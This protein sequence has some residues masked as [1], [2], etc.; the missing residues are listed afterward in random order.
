MPAARA[1]CAHTAALYAQF[2]SVQLVLARLVL[3]VAGVA[4][5]LLEVEIGGLFA[6]RAID[7]YL[8]G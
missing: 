5:E 6:C 2:V 8:R 1:G 3:A 7:G 4:V